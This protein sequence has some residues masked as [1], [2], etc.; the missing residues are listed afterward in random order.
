MPP[1]PQFKVVLL[2]NGAV[3]KSSI[4]LRYTQNVFE[5]NHITTVQAAF[6]EKT[7]NVDGSRVTLA[8]WVCTGEGRDKS[9]REIDRERGYS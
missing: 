5:P 9:E 7:L 8:I 1:S 2:G 4:V 6:R 3:G